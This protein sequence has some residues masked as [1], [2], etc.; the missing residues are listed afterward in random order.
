MPQRPF[1]RLDF[2][3]F[4]SSPNHGGRHFLLAPSF[5]W[6]NYGPDQTVCQQKPTYC[7]SVFD[8]FV[9]LELKGLTS[10]T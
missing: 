8:Q 5:F 6:E 2:S 3:K 4:S 1:E 7:L 9:G 10:G